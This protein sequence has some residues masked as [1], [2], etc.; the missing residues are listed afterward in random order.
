MVET[1]TYAPQKQ[2]QHIDFELYQNSLRVGVASLDVSRLGFLMKEMPW[3]TVGLYPG[4][5]GSAWDLDLHVRQEGTSNAVVASVVAPDDGRLLLSRAIPLNAFLWF[6]NAVALKAGIQGTYLIQ[7]TVPEA[8]AEDRSV[9]WQ[10][11]DSDGVQFDCEETARLLPAPPDFVSVGGNSFVRRFAGLS[12]AGASDWLR[13]VFSLPALKKFLDLARRETR[14]ERHFLGATDHYVHPPYVYCYVRDVTEIEGNRTRY[15]VETRG[16][17]LYQAGRESRV[18]NRA[19]SASAYLHLHPPN[20]EDKAVLTPSP[21]GADVATFGNFDR[22]TSRPTVF[23]IALFNTSIS[24]QARPADVEDAF[25]VW[26]YSQ[27]M[28][29]KTNWVVEQ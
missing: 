14:E 29:S 6:T 4:A 22:L 19:G 9:R 27:G 12:T 25:V 3:R 28:L 15:G 7:A 5:G 21:S 16:D 10:A 26:S 18:G 24:P 11:S 20:V 8:R 1:A 17:Q 13:C 23:P 2:R